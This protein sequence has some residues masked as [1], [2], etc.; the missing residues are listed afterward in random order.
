M[1][2]N[3]IVGYGILI[4]LV[5]MVGCNNAHAQTPQTNQNKVEVKATQCKGITQ[6]KVQCKRKTK[7]I[8]GFCYQHKPVKK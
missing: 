6:K 5:S 2:L 3:K 8:T 7:D 4:G 1:K